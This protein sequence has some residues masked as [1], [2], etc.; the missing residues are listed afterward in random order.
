MICGLHR[1]V[2]PAAGRQLLIREIKPL[3]THLRAGNRN[4]R[5]ASGQLSDVQ[6]S[7]KQV[8]CPEM[9]YAAEGDDRAV[10]QRDA[11]AAV[12]YRG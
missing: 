3:P 6:S 2:A 1:I 4:K 12:G 5:I 10:G 11:C 8:A 7:C 9:A